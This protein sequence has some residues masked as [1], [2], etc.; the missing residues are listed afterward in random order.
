MCPTE[1]EKKFYSE[2]PSQQKPSTP[3][4]AFLI[5][6]LLFHFAFFLIQVQ[7]VKPNTEHRTEIEEINSEKVQRIR[8]K[9]KEKSLLLTKNQNEP[10]EKITPPHARYFSDRNRSFEKEQRARQT[11]VLPHLNHRDP[12]AKKPH[13][14]RWAT[15]K[16][17]HFIPFGKL[18]LGIPLRLDGKPMRESEQLASRERNENREPNQDQSILDH[19]LEIGSENRLN[20]QESLYYS[21]Y[22][23]LYQAI[24]PLWSSQIRQV[25][26][27]K[28][29][30]P[31]EYVTQVDIVLDEKGNLKQIRL[32]EPSGIEEFDKAVEESWKKIQQFP[33]P[34]RGLLSENQ[35]IHVAW[36]FRVQVGPGLDFDYPPPKRR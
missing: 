4:L 13:E 27:Q 3:F 22:S 32:L 23:R 15:S 8:K 16:A 34:P 1:I 24:A 7:W 20:T 29:I 19:K 33:N 35:E 17:K 11:D 6:A 25:P 30:Y 26:H 18:K 5:L 31:G 21:F 2:D 28:A 14:K 9:W 12:N 10:S 36:S